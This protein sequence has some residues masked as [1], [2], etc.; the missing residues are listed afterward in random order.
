VGQ[1]QS[2]VNMLGNWAGGSPCEIGISDRWLDAMRV[3]G[4]HS[5]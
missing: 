3:L 5:R 4:K 1:F 2:A